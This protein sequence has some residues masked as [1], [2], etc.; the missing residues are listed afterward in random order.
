LTR[1]AFRV[2]SRSE[3]DAE[4]RQKAATLSLKGVAKRIACPLFLVAGKLDRIV[5][6]EHAQRLSREA[7]GPV[8]MLVIENGTHVVNNRPHRYRTQTADWLAEQLRTAS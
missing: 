8:E 4:A 1:T 5:P 3:S 7:T 6:W 2:R